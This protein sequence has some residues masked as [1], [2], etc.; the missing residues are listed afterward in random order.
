LPRRLP[1]REPIGAD[2]GKEKKPGVA[3]GF[4]AMM[5]RAG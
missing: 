3:P 5:R 4:S 1:G 2:A